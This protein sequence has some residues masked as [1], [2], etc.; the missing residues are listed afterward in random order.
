[1]TCVQ[2][3][4]VSHGHIRD[5]KAQMSGDKEGKRALD[6]E[7]TAAVLVRSDLE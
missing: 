5:S 4:G 6:G 3:E 1:M 7:P 2:D